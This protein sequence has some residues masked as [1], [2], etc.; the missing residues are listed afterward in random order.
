M[1]SE[2]VSIEDTDKLNQWL[3]TELGPICEADP[4]QLSKYVF[5]LIKKPD[6]TKTQLKEFCNGQLEAFLSTNTKPFVD[7]LFDVLSDNSYVRPKAKKEPPPAP[8]S[9]VEEPKEKLKRG[10]ENEKKNEDEPVEKRKTNSP[11]REV[12]PKGGRALRGQNAAASIS[13]PEEQVS[14]A[15]KLGSSA[16]TSQKVSQPQRIV[17]KRI[18]PPPPDEKELRRRRSR[19]PPRR[20][21]LR[22]RSPERIV[23][24]RSRSRSA[25][26]KDE[27]KKKQRCRDYDEQGFCMRGDA[28]Q[29]DHGPDPVVID[30]KGWKS[31][32][33]GI[34]TKPPSF[35][36]AP[37]NFNLPPP[38]YTPIGAAQPPPPGIVADG[39]Y[40]PD[41]PAMSLDFSVPPPS[42]VM[43]AGWRPNIQFGMQQQGQMLETG[44]RAD[45][46]YDGP[47][48]RGAWGGRGRGGRGGNR[49]LPRVRNDVGKSL[50]VRNIP[51]ELNNILKLNEHFM[52][53][54]AIVNLQ[55]HFQGDPGAALVTYSSRG[56]ATNAYKST[57]PILNNRFI[58]VFWHNP[59]EAANGEPTTANAA[60]GQAGVPVSVGADGEK[61]AASASQPSETKP[62]SPKKT[63]VVT[64]AQAVFRNEKFEEEMKKKVADREARKRDKVQLANLQQ[65]QKKKTELVQKLLTQ[66]KA[67]FELAKKA[68]SDEPKKKAL[69]LVAKLKKQIDTLRDEQKQATEKI[70][71]LQQKRVEEEEAAKKAAEASKAP[72][73]ADES[74]E[75]T[76]SQDADKVGK[77]GKTLIIRGFDSNDNIDELRLTLEIGGLNPASFEVIQLGKDAK[78][79]GTYETPEKARQA[80]ITKNIV[81]EGRRVR[82]GW[83]TQSELDQKALPTTE[84]IVATLGQQSDSETEEPVV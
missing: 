83:P 30:E 76:A 59:P 22:R 18:S 53:F 52:Q 9:K 54:G 67:A 17:R 28:C 8:S 7:K 12:S 3:I 66:Q 43:N 70:E 4:A 10:K 51:A 21:G 58:K 74:V 1:S 6:K 62:A 38:G 50:E 31:S 60:T 14:S 13:P 39:G 47:R 41:A 45:R 20:G 72:I 37:P 79:L 57:N 42:L 11:K 36:T 73:T 33:K 27:R 46:G 44:P 71:E 78:A 84:D 77:D 49:M 34:I 80:V 29:F 55:V 48:G 26:R 75:S 23:R 56:E 81:H 32:S 16:E 2:Y 35:P 19:S 40:N 63:E 65:M 69:K 25:D 82:F 68:T 5:A 61:A 15:E 64:R 24:R